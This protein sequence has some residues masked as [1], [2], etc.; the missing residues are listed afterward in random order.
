MQ[1]VYHALAAWQDLD[2]E[3]NRLTL[4]V[5]VFDLENLSGISK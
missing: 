3:D 1:P 5:P 4:Q 2:F